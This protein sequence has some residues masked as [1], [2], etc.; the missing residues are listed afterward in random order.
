[1]A[2]NY[3][4]LK[5]EVIND[6]L[7]RGYLG[8]TNSQVAIS[9]NTVNR[10]RER[11]VVPSHEVFE[12]IDP[13]ELAGLSTLQRQII[14]GLLAM[15]EVNL[16]GANTRLALKG[17]FGAGTASRAALLSI[18]TEPVSRAKELELGDVYEGHII[19]VRTM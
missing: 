4:K 1:M 15:G 2:F 10:T 14:L 19:A 9:L 16:K 3:A 6:P 7:G 5:T 12:A 13:V 17:A 11:T 8:M 18:Q